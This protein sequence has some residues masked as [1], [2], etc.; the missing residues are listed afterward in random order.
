MN[1][2]EGEKKG[3]KTKARGESFALLITIMRLRLILIARHVSL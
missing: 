2:E 1:G 3:K